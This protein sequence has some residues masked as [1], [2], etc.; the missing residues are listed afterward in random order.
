MNLPKNR[1]SGII[2]LIALM[3]LATYYY[4]YQQ[5]PSMAS[6]QVQWQGSATHFLEKDEK[7]QK[8]LTNKIIVLSGTIS[9]LDSTSI[10]INNTVFCSMEGK[11]EREK[12]GLGKYVKVKGRLMGYDELLEELKLDA[13]IIILE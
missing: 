1:I 10:T 3:G 4:I 8:A 5:H 7:E 11:Q 12:I 13:C 2:A 6:L 9:A